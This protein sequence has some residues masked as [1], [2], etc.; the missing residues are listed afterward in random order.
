MVSRFFGSGDPFN[1]L[2]R[3]VNRVFDEVVLACHAD[4]ALLICRTL[5][6]VPDAVAASTTGFD[7]DALELLAT[8]PG[9]EQR[10][11]VRA[12]ACRG[13]FC[14]MLQKTGGRPR[15]G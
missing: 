5:G 9:G 3:E 15:V 12:G 4:D 14:S 7:G 6:S 11:R 10:V 13:S 2:H 1:Q 8:G